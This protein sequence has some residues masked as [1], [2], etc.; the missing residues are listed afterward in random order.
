[1]GIW[2]DI[3]GTSSKL[4]KLGK[5]G[6]LFDSNAPTTNR[7]F[8]LPD[9]NVDLSGGTVGQ[10]LKKLSATAIGWANESGG[11]GG[12]IFYRSFSKAGTTQAQNAPICPAILMI[13]NCTISLAQFR[14]SQPAQDDTRFDLLKNGVSILSGE[15][16]MLSG[17]QISNLATFSDNAFV[18]GDILELYIH[19]ASL[20]YFFVDLSS[21]LKFSL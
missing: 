15:W 5:V 16:K 1:M 21:S 2:S 13:E 7:T 20:N 12:Q 11:G 9:A 8:T 19:N 14:F 17:Q 18:A 3:R 6:T 10:V 4:F